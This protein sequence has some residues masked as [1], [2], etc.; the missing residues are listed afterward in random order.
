VN[1]QNW[2]RLPNMIIL[3]LIVLSTATMLL[4]GYLLGLRQNR[5]GLPTA[6]MIFIYATVYLI[7]IDLD[8]PR[9]GMFTIVSDQ[10]TASIEES[11]IQVSCWSSTFQ[12]RRASMSSRDWA[13]GS[14]L[15]MRRR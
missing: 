10:P 1:V 13:A 2:M 8:R 14:S 15:K 7:V 11:S 4:T 6:L 9:R 5:Y 12:G 3:V